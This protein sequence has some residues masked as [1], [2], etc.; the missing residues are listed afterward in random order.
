[1]LSM[2]KSQSVGISIHDDG[3]GDAAAAVA[4][5][6]GSVL[7]LPAAAMVLVIDLASTPNCNQQR[8]GGKKSVILAGSS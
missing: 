8:I 2:L 1:M 7:G 6:D 5:V 4:I 3:D